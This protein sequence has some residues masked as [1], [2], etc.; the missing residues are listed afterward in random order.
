VLPTSAHLAARHARVRQKLDTLSVDALV[1][2]CSANIRYLSN[3]VGSSGVLI[4]TE[5]AAHLLVDFRYREVVKMLQQSPAA[6][7]DLVVHDVPASYDEA[8]LE[9]LREIG[10]STVGFEAA[11]VSV[12]KHDWWQRTADAR[13]LNLVWR[14]TDRVVEEVRIVKDAPEIDTIREAAARLGPVADAV[15]GAVRAGR[16]ER[17]VA[18]VL[19]AAIR[20]AGYERL[21]FDTIVASGPHAALPHYRAGDRLLERADVVVLDFGGVYDSYCVDLTRTVS[22]GTPSA[23]ARRSV[24]AVDGAVVSNPSAKKMTSR[25]GF[26]FA[27]R[28]A[29]SGE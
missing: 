3:H 17:A 18:A 5:D 12:A 14:P 24:S 20:E 29:S 15:F 22:V 28:S 23:R 16:T 19:E 1:V 7:P 27:R 2:T 25:S 9:C 10:V 6:C 4:L 21:A 13:T 8:L 26:R 11:H